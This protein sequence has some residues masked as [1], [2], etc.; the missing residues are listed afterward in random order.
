MKNEKILSLLEKIEINAD[1]STYKPVPG[2]STEYFEL[3]RRRFSNPSIQDTI[4]RVAFD[5][6]SH[7]ILDS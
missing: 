3:I 2:Y 6:S 5:G 1:Y 7:V 4:R